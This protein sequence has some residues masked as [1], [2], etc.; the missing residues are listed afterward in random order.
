MILAWSS[1]RCRGFAMAVSLIAAAPAVA[2]APER[3]VPAKLPA[4]PAEIMAG[5]GLANQLGSTGLSISAG[6]EAEDASAPFSASPIRF[7][8]ALDLEGNPIRIALGK[9]TGLSPARNF[10][11][12]GAVSVPTGFPVR[13]VSMSGGFGLRSHPILGGTRFHSG[14]DLTASTGTTVSATA[15]GMVAVSGW[16]GGLGWCVVVDHGGGYTTVYGHMSSLDVQAGQEIRSGQRVGQ[17]GST[18]QS[19]GPHLHYEVRFQDRPLNP[20]RFL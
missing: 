11:W 15:A 20:S 18:G 17:V 7:G 3:G 13:A 9:G 14:I 19:T 8:R 12:S 16:C 2:Q 5:A 1:L 10:R 4:K 6:S